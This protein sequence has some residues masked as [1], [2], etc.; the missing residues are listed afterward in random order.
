MPSL[1]KLYAAGGHIT[2]DYA[3]IDSDGVTVASTAFFPGG[4][5]RGIFYDV[6]RADLYMGSSVRQEGG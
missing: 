2:P 5:A 4:G 3:I 1:G 6:G